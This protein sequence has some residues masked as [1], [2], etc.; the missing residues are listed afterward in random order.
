VTEQPLLV[1]DNVS[2]TYGGVRAVDEVS[3]TVAPGSITA[4]IGP[5]GAGKS[6]L[7]NVV[8]GFDRAEA[9]TVAFGG[10]AMLGL[11]PHRIAKRGLVRT[12]QLTRTF[13]A[14]SVVDNMLAATH[15]HPGERLLTALLARRRVGDHE[16]AVRERARELLDLFALT[17]VADAYAGQ[18]SGGQRKL[19]ELARAL[20]LEPTMVLLDEPMAG[21]NPVLGRRLMEHIHRLRDERGLTFFF[22]EHDMDA[23][24]RH[25]DEVVV[26]AQGRVLVEGPPAEVQADTRVVDAYL[27][28][29]SG[30]QP[31]SPAVESGET[32]PLVLRV[33]DLVAGYVPGVDILR[34]VHVEVREGE[35]VTIVGPNGAGKST[36]V[37]ALV[38]ILRPR[39][40]RI[41]LRGDEI[42]DLSGH[43]IVHKGV[44]YVPQRDNVFPSL[45]VEENL[46]LGA[47]RR[48]GTSVRERIAEI[49][50]LFPLLAKRGKQQAGSLSGGEHQML[51]LGR[52]LM[53]DPAV[54]LLDEPSAGLAPALVGA[55]FEKIVEVNAAGVTILMV[56]QNARQALALS[57]RGYVLDVGQNRFEGRGGDLLEDPQ[58]GRLYLGGG[59][60]V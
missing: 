39:A 35:I 52:A 34:G 18:L 26:V 33:E 45:T 23:V 4:L 14:I 13:E 38:G 48:S 44:A 25:A 20:M 40:G 24:M 1:L 10:R 12:F 5:N 21:V 56:E 27:G 22:V 2:K 41:F 51:A 42:T 36:L 30:P 8:T 19:L 60:R 55:M 46:E 31:P 7:F 54:L 17:E 43:E 49:V 47:L 58:V 37:K 3:L 15:G 9:G 50:A 11:P 28:S 32:R 53:A 59:G 57:T 16:R 6:T 29:A